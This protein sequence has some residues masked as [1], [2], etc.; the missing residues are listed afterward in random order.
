MKSLETIAERVCDLAKGTHAQAR[1]SRSRHGL[2]R[3]ANSF[4]HQH[5]G[6]DTTE[7][8]VK[9]A[10][11]GRVASAATTDT[12][13][14]GLSR[15]VEDARAAA[16]LQPVDPHWPGV[17]GHADIPDFNRCSEATMQAAPTDRAEGV[18]AFIDSAT[19]LTAA[20]YLDTM[21]N[22]VAV[23]TTGGQL[24]SGRT[25]RAT[26]DGIQRTPSSAGNGHQTDVDF[27]QLDGSTVGARATDFAR[28]GVDPV[29]LDPGE[30]TVVLSPECVATVA[31]FLGAYGFGG[32][33]FLDGQSFVKLGERQFDPA[34]RLVDDPADPRSIALPF[35]VDG[36]PKATLPLVDD[37]VSR[38]IAH[39]RRTAMRADTES[40]G[41]AVPVSAF[42]P[43]P[44]S[45]VVG[46]GSTSPEDLVAGVDRGVFVSTF[47][48]CRILDPRTQV[49]TG[50]TR[51]GTFLIEDGEV[52]TPLTNL[53]FTQ[54]FLEAL[55]EGTIEAI[56]DDQ[57]YADSEFGPGF[58]IAPSMRLS[59]WNF[60]GGARG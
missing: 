29:D 8:A 12:S 2:T 18:A 20:G 26:I 13:E 59:S 52:T 11:D 17:S 4:I 34:F 6:E 58:V 47:N 25:S 41:H 27:S 60:T 22:E 43:V 21:V 15:L 37:G 49:V 16:E 1:V 24:V 10:V 50:L 33:S 19:D 57:R 9:L 31:I 51:N 45:L 14:E 3:F 30:Y 35:D 7:A 42:G 39:D 46:G 28:R 23:A 54:S 40:T 36:T 56:G 53:R 48:Y 55:T 38:A 44:T 5:H 32:K